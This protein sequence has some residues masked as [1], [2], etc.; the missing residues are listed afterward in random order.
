VYDTGNG[1]GGFSDYAVC[2]KGL[3]LHYFKGPATK[4]KV[5]SAV[6]VKVICPINQHVVGGGEK[7]TGTPAT[8]RMIG[9]FPFD[10][11][12]KDK[13]PDDGWQAKVYNLGGGPKTVTGWA[14][15]VG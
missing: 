14:I 7:L 6:T 3:K 5:K 10:G 1:I 9:T 12:D 11:P 2:S 4:V 13:I 15:C 8:G